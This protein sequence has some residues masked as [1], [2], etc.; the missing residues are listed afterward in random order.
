MRNLAAG[1]LL[2]TL[3]TACAM[4]ETRIYSLD[5]ANGAKPALMVP[6][7]TAVLIVDSPRRLAQPF[8]VYRNSP[9][10]IAVSRYAKWHAPPDEM[11]RDAFKDSL[12]PA[13][14]KEVTAARSAPAGAYTLKVELKR[15]ERVE[16]GDAFFAEIAYE[17]ELLSPDGKS[18]Y[19]QS[20]TKRIPLRDRSFLGLAKGLSAALGAG[21]EEAERSMALTLSAAGAKP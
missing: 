21:T 19:R 5:P 16:E 4:Q 13:L 3:V 15:F 7:A 10:Q 12:V 6:D 8:I 14:F 20:F 17:L 18:L 9:N 1:L 2:G 11:V